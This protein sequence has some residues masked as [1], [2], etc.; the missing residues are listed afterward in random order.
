[1]AVQVP[2]GLPRFSLPDHAFSDVSDLGDVIAACVPVALVAF[3]SQWSV[4]RKYADK[5]NQVDLLDPNQEAFALGRH[6]ERK[7]G[8]GGG[9]RALA[10]VGYIGEERGGRESCARPWCA[11]LM[12]L[13][14]HAVCGCCRRHQPDRRLL[15]LL[16][17]RSQVRHP[18]FNHIRVQL[19][20]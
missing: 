10:G 17:L 9:L 8:G 1:V 7:K 14:W 15:P 20:L 18:Q 11:E 12:W 19:S 16:P 5:T 4:A 13:Y 2:T 3:M 6:R